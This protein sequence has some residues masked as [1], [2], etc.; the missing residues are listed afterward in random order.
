MIDVPLAGPTASDELRRMF[1]DAC[2]RPTDI[3]QHL[4]VLRDTASGVKHITE[5]GV[6][7]GQSTLA[8]LLVQPD[9]L[10]C[11]D[12][13]FQDCVPT[14]QRVKGAT[15]F[16]FYIADTRIVEIE[17]TDL[18]FID[19]RHNYDQL[20]EELEL[21]PSKVRR[22]IVLHDTTTFADHGEDGK[23]PGLWQAVEE[24]LMAHPEWEL[25]ARFTHNNGL[26][27]LKNIA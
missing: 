10:V 8:W 19:T 12:W 14:L 1:L 15:D 2:A 7:T 25:M 22:Y 24:F 6:G 23:P 11:Y 20:S 18:L 4:T 26:S 5:M 27:I 21:H 17:P 13:G 3:H 16:R 9:K